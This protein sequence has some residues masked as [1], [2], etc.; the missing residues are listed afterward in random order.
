MRWQT[1]VI[2]NSLCNPREDMIHSYLEILAWASY[3]D[4]F[5]TDVACFA[6]L[7]KQIRAELET[8]TKKLESFLGHLRTARSIGHSTSVR[9][10]SLA[11][12]NVKC[13]GDQ[14]YRKIPEY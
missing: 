2:R 4:S 12:S 9:L 6:T 8:L 5:L 14:E 7:R 11:I 13:R 10:L 1:N 3:T